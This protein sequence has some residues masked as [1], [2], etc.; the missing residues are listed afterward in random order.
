MEGEMGKEEVEEAE[1]EDEEDEDEDE[2]GSAKEE[3]SVIEGV[4]NL[5]RG[6][7][8]TEECIDFSP[9]GRGKAGKI[10]LSGGKVIGKKCILGQDMFVWRETR[11]VTKILKTYE[12][13]N[14]LIGRKFC[15]KTGKEQTYSLNIPRDCVDSLLLA[16]KMLWTL[17][18][19]ETRAKETKKVGKKSKICKV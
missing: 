12:F 8:D 2:G 7:T 11:A 19:K 9:E 18:Q 16:L 6:R 5:T 13:E 1:E 4:A 10:K 15:D 3:E 14:F 17:S